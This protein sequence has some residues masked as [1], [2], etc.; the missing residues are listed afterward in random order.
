MAHSARLSDEFDP[1]DRISQ[2]AATIL[3]FNSFI[4]DINAHSKSLVLLKKRETSL[5]MARSIISSMGL[6]DQTQTCIYLIISL[7]VLDDAFAYDDYYLMS[8]VV[9]FFCLKFFG[10]FGP[11]LKW[12][13]FLRESCAQIASKELLSSEFKL[14]SFLDWDVFSKPSIVEYMDALN[15]ILSPLFLLGSRERQL[16]FK[17]YLL[18]W[19]DEFPQDFI[20][21]SAGVA[22]L[23]FSS[24][25]G[26]PSLLDADIILNKFFASIYFYDLGY[27]SIKAEEYYVRL[28]L[29][30]M[31]N[32]SLALED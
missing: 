14:L 13:K 4:E 25:S 10:D 27:K 18:L 28:Q 22:A 19:I 9:I 23:A 2:N 12:I 8:L 15:E 3:D 29:I 24:H 32:P 11:Q 16:S 17:L 30:I 31:Q 6:Q 20:S 1:D 21:A 7:C 5:K 26:L